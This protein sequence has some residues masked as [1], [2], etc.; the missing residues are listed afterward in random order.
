M[1]MERAAQEQS[2]GC[3]RGHALDGAAE[4]ALEKLWFWAAFP[5]TR[6]RQQLCHKEGLQHHGWQATAEGAALGC[7]LPA[8]PGSG[9]QCLQGAH[10]DFSITASMQTSVSPEPCLELL[11]R[12]AL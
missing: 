5:E 11:P 9:K 8:Q 12:A 1:C 2:D 4:L 7:E 10:S 6:P 3:S